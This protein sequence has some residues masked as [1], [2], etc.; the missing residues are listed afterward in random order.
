MCDRVA[1]EFEDGWVVN[2]GAGIP[3]LCS[4]FDFGDKMIVFHS[5]NGVLGYGPIAAAGEENPYLVNAGNDYVTLVPYTA[6]VHHADSFALIRGGHVDAVVMG[7]YEV[8]QNGDLANWKIA[9]RRGGAIGGAMDLAVGAKR[10]LIVMEHVTRDGRPRL[11]RRCAMPLTA[12]GCV[13]MV[14]TN[15][16]LFDVRDEAF[17]L[18]EIAPGVTVEEI[19]ALTEGDVEVCAELRVVPQISQPCRRTG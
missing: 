18:R 14:V 4:N 6:V 17:N 19:R 8:A 9:G 11:R 3:T 1:M 15:L 5:E 16:G 2:L 12:I 13:D 10:V 7:A